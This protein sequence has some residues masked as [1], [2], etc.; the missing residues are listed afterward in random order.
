[1]TN[2]TWIQSRNI[3]V[4]TLMQRRTTLCVSL[5]CCWIC[6]ATT[7][8][9]EALFPLPDVIPHTVP[10]NDREGFQAE[11]Q[12][13]VDAMF[14][15]LLL[16]IDE[17]KRV[18]VL[19]ESQERSLLITAKGVVQQS[20]DRWIAVI[21]SMHSARS[22][23][24]HKHIQE[25]AVFLPNIGPARVRAV[26]V[27]FDGEVRRMGVIRRKQLDENLL[28]GLRNV[29]N[30][31]PKANDLVGP[32]EGQQVGEV[33]VQLNDGEPNPSPLVL[34]VGKHDLWVAALDRALNDHQKELYAVAQA[35][36]EALPREWRHERVMIEFDRMLRL[37]S[38][39]RGPLAE[40]V[41]EF[42]ERTQTK[43]WLER[44]QGFED[45]ALARMAVRAIQSD[46]VKDILSSRQLA[47][48][49]FMLRED[50]ESR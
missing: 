7:A 14:G 28:D 47:Q 44:K 17:L 46:D 38:T 25:K 33:A 11:A 30:A 48:W 24:D 12:K 26:Q 15:Q 13:L 37:D 9:A 29:F 21:D 19:T 34:D 50:L 8:S 16:H 45:A 2:E 3:L 4:M 42:L 1:M 10:E 32:A 39:Q 43:R 31:V 27:V 36:R 6:T 18:C 35:E 22:A 49:Q 20:L 41:G 40:R 5:I 23:A